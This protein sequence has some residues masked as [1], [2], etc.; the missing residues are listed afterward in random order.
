MFA[1]ARCCAACTDS[2][3]ITLVKLSGT[4]LGVGVTVW[5]GPGAGVGLRSVVGVVSV[6]LGLP[7]LGGSGSVSHSVGD[8]SNVVA[9]CEAGEV[10]GCPLREFCWLDE[11]DEFAPDTPALWPGGLFLKADDVTGWVSRGSTTVAAM[12]TMARAPTAASAGRTQD[13]S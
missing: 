4:G 10:N 1:A 2:S 13:G 8:G 3:P 12:A 5:L 9:E 7:V 11:L 6:G